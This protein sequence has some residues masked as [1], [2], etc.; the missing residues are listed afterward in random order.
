MRTTIDRTAPLLPLI[1]L[2]LLVG[3]GVVAVFIRRLDTPIFIVWAAGAL[4]LL[5]F[6][7]LRPD[8]V[9]HMLSGRQARFGLS[10]LM[11]ILFFAAI[12]VLLYWIVSQ[13][14]DW[15][16]DVTETQEFTPLPE[17]VELLESLDSPIHVIGFYPVSFAGQ[18][19]QA[20]RR[21]K[22][23]TTWPPSPTT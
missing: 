4:L 23:S 17:T 18:K 19:D 7:A 2:I 1:G 15:R 10:T 8:D 6:A 22:F 13:F 5:L 20:T 9:R 12:A 16:L 21:R 14:D 11:A 3:G